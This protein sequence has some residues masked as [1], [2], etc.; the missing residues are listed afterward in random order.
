MTQESLFAHRQVSVTVDFPVG[1][2][3]VSSDAR[4]GRFER[5]VHQ[6]EPIVFAVCR[7]LAA[8]EAQAS[9]CC[10][11]AFV[12]AFYL[13]Q[14]ATASPAVFL[15]ETMRLALERIDR[16]VPRL[17][18]TLPLPGM[19]ANWG[20]LSSDDRNILALRFAGRLELS[21]IADILDL[22]KDAVRNRLWAAMQRLGGGLLGTN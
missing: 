14:D 15:R 11:D 13:P 16:V 10:E 17:T 8:G 19:D 22:P 5:L 7:L 12:E 1:A 6:Y 18:S 2:S 9:Q 3:P 4:L 21:E 20:G